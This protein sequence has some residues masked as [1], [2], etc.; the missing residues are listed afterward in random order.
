MFQAKLECCAA[1]TKNYFVVKYR[2]MYQ[3]ISYYDVRLVTKTISFTSGI[4]ACSGW[5]KTSLL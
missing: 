2:Y 3:H 5:V 4:I 1:M